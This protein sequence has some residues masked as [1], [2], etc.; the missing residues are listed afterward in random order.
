[1]EGNISVF[2]HLGW[3]FQAIETFA[4]R[5]L[6]TLS[7]KGTLFQQ[8]TIRKNTILSEIDTVHDNQWH[9]QLHDWAYTVVIPQVSAPGLLLNDRDLTPE[10]W[11]RRKYLLHF[12]G[13]GGKACGNGGQEIRDVLHDS[14]NALKCNH[15]K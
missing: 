8:I 12:R 7:N 15:S 6:T 3:E 1:M 14:L 2:Y 13:R 5:T 11:S 10:S 9:R 4:P